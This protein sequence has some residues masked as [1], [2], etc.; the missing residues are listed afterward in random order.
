MTFQCF[1]SVSLF[2]CVEMVVLV[3]PNRA[4]RIRWEYIRLLEG[5]VLIRVSLLGANVLRPHNKIGDMLLHD[6]LPIACVFQ[7]QHENRYVCRSIMCKELVP[8]E[9]ELLLHHIYTCEFR[10][11]LPMVAECGRAYTFGEFFNQLRNTRLT[12]FQAWVE[13]ILQELKKTK[14]SAG[15]LGCARWI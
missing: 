14:T 6:F 10:Q 1:E 12:Q 13:S 7:A 8:V 11:S 15:Q 5:F 2:G 3:G 9:I 4:E